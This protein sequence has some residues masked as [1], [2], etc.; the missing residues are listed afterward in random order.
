MAKAF[1][2]TEYNGWKAGY[3]TWN[4]A[5]WLSNDETAYHYA[6]GLTNFEQDIT[7][8]LEDWTDG[9]EVA[10]QEAIRGWAADNLGYLARSVNWYQVHEALKAG[11]TVTGDA[12]EPTHEAWE[13][14]RERDWQD[15]VEGAEYETAADSMLRDWLVD[16]FTTYVQSPAARRHKNSGLSS[17]ARTFLNIARGAVDFDKVAEEFS[18]D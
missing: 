18:E 13:M 4:L 8:Q 6:Q 5:L 3:P 15:I 7:Q 12:D 17:I 9:E 14:L 2:Y 1:E 10:C 11:I 16:K